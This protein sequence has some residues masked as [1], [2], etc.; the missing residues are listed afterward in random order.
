M[1]TEIHGQPLTADGY[2]ALGVHFYQTQRY[3]DACSAALRGVREYPHDGAL[4]Q[5][6][7]C[8]SA[9]L[10]DWSSTR[11]ALETACTLVP[12]ARTSQLAL[13]NSYLHLGQPKVARTMLDYLAQQDHTPETL[14][15]ELADALFRA[16]RFHRALRL[17]EQLIERY[18]FA[19]GARVGLAK[20][21][22]ALG[23][24]SAEVVEPLLQAV[25]LAP[26]NVAYRLTLANVYAQ[27]RLYAPAAEVLLPI[28][29]DAVLCRGCLQ[30]MADLFA[31][32]G[33]P[34]R[35]AQCRARVAAE[36][37]EHPC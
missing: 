27:E 26:T 24:P 9:V 21:R 7:G 29:P 10:R 3:A 23:A 18:P 17:W 19:A 20:C 6:L 31:W 2:Y 30:R 8:A 13:A 12:L 5:V 33:H 36:W 1:S 15:P 14:W 34:E 4:W 32:G 16:E 25:Q 28:E 11:H 35:A 37:D 22:F